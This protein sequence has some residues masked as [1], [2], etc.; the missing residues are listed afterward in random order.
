MYYQLSFKRIAR[1]LCMMLA[2][3]IAPCSVKA[4]G[5]FRK[6]PWPELDIAFCDIKSVTSW[7]VS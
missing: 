6:P 3:M 7:R 2:A 4:R 5:S 1:S